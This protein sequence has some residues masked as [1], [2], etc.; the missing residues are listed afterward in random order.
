MTL[1][2]RSRQSGVPG[3]ADAVRGSPQ[4]SERWPVWS[5]G[6]SWGATTQTN[7]RRRY[8]F[9]FSPV[10]R[11][12]TTN[13]GSWAVLPYQTAPA[14]QSQLPNLPHPTALSTGG[15]EVKQGRSRGSWDGRAACGRSFCRCMLRHLRFGKPINRF[16]YFFLTPWR[17][18]AW[19]LGAVAWCIAL[20]VVFI[21]G[22]G[23]NQW[24]GIASVIPIIAFVADQFRRNGSFNK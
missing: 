15:W 5:F 6:W 13:D 20:N 9:G 14:W 7:G 21:A 1:S 4:S 22:G 17:R 16:V 23:S 2:M 12:Q 18:S 24:L 8:A 3:K 10:A 11:G 19:F